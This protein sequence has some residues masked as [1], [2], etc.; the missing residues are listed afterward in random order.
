MLEA[1][2]AADPV[3]P[4]GTGVGPESHPGRAVHVGISV[5]GRTRTVVQCVLPVPCG[6]RARSLREHGV[7]MCVC[8]HAHVCDG[9]GGPVGAAGS[10]TGS[11]LLLCI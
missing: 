5:A 4:V 9:P 6:S 10:V 8:V 11:Q 7:M 1:Q 2:P 3:H